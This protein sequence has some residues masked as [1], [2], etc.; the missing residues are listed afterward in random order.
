M[1]DKN[2]FLHN[3]AVVAILKN[4]GPYLKEWLDYHL[5]AGVEHFYLYDNE[6]PDNQ[7]EVAKPY[8]EAG[9]VD[10]FPLPGKVMQCAAYNDAV[11]R[12]KFHCRYMAFIDGD[13]FIFPKS[14]RS[15]VE[16]VDEILSGN[17][18]AAGLAINWQMFGSNGQVKA[19]YS[20]GVLERFTRRAPKDYTP[21]GGETNS[22]IKTVTNPRKINFFG[23]PHFSN[24][25]EGCYSVNENGKLVTGGYS[26]PVT[27]EKI[28]VNHYY[29]KSY[30]EYAKKVNRGRSDILQ[31]REL[32][33][34]EHDDRNEEFDDDIL[35]YRDAQAKTYQ[36]P[37]MAHAD[38]KL[39][40]ALAKNLSPTLMPTTPPQF[41]A[42]KTET[43]LT[44]RAIAAYLKTKLTDDTP[45]KF[46][47]EVSLNA[48]LKSL[49]GMNFAD[50]RLLIRELPNLLSLPYPAVKDLR[51][52]ALNFIPQM[53]NVTRRNIMWKDYVELDYLQDLLKLI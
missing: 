21:A 44:C 17:P 19:D 14:N 47:E 45:A 8:V 3:L 46:F 41:Y 32:K 4:E 24:Y 26:A 6:S 13:E 22:L 50:A 7:A 27:A 51:G 9:L 18:N 31:P 28:V 12:F 49:G 48:I 11:K 2:L 20:R 1:V 53:M 33:D 37:D 36:P 25:F 23:S 30:E 15:I 29:T 10:Y 16:V 52:A 34:F 35:K 42:G 5:L 40:N 39:F 43:F 38:E